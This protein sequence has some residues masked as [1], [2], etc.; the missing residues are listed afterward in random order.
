MKATLLACVAAT[1]CACCAEG[2]AHVYQG[3]HEGN[4][5]LLKH[6]EL[7]IS[8]NI[9]HRIRRCDH[10][11]SEYAGADE[12]AFGL[13]RLREAYADV[14]DVRFPLPSDLQGQTFL[15]YCEARLKPHVLDASPVIQRM[16][17]ATSRG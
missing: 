6:L 8:R 3:E 5:T 17:A 12:M 11:G 9:A 7:K 14:G 1:Q 10:C 16:R 4:P 2:Q 13:T 15:Q